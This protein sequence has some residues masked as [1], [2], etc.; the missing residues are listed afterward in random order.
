MSNFGWSFWTLIPTLNVKLDVINGHSFINLFITHTS[1]E[2]LTKVQFALEFAMRGKEAW[3]GIK[4]GE[5]LLMDRYK[6]KK[7][8]LTW[9]NGMWKNLKKIADV[10]IKDFLK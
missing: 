10:L 8:L 7:K 5:C 1:V 2:Y 3:A 4:I 6:N 9:E